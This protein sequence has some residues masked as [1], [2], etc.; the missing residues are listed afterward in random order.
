VTTMFGHDRIYS[1][2]QAFRKRLLEPAP[3]NTVLR[4]GQC[5]LTPV[6]RSPLPPLDF[7]LTVIV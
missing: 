1:G 4:S 3:K 2:Q 5:A 7:F 6:G